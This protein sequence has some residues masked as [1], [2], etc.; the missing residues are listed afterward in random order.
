MK[1]VTVEYKGTTE[2][3][4][5]EDD[6]TFGEIEGVQTRYLKLNKIVEGKVDIDVFAYGR[7]LTLVA[8]KKA[9]W[10]IHDV[11][12]FRNLSHKLAYSMVREVM[13]I[14]PLGDSLLG[15]LQTMA[16]ESVEK[17]MAPSSGQKKQ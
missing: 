7:E 6:L 11:M 10:K 17:L 8:I 2:T 12:A 16:G 3:V 9:P 1:T 4:E 5:I 13:E 14:Y 15:L